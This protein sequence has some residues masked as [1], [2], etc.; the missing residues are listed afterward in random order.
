M[1]WRRVEPL[2]GSRLL[3]LVLTTCGLFC[4]TCLTCTARNYN[5]KYSLKF[6]L[7][8]ILNDALR[9]HSSL[10]EGKSMEVRIVVRQGQGCWGLL[11]WSY[12]GREKPLAQNFLHHLCR[13]KTNVADELSFSLAFFCY[14]IFFTEFLLCV[15]QYFISAVPH[16]CHMK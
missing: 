6:S 14:F 11:M 7:M 4:I 16:K 3:E 5:W 12:W 9:D 1:F 13:H 8:R 15:L 2:Q 10:W